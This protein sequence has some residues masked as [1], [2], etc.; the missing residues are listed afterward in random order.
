[1]PTPSETYIENRARIQPDMTNNYDTAHGGEVMKLM[2]EVGAMSAMRFA[3]ETCVTAQVTGLE[4]TRPIPRGEVAVVEA[5]A[6]QAGRSS[7]RI[8]LVVD[9]EDPRTGERERT[10]DSCLVFVAVDEDGAPVAVPELNTPT[11]R[12]RQLEE[13]GLAA[14]RGE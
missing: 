4:F 12:D 13:S 8:R 6:Y 1:M 9:R 5:W 11:D 3:G 7:I 14:D 10:C 2:D